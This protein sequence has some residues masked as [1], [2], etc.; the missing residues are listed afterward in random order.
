MSDSQKYYFVAASRKYLC[1]DEGKPLGE[2]LSERRRNFEARGKEINFWLIE[3]PAFLELPELAAV[4]RQIPQP[5]A[6][7]VTTDVNTMRW[8]KLRLE[9]VV[10]GEFQTSAALPD[11]LASLAIA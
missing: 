8:L 9:F 3:Q 6:A 10:T 1:E 2:T 7:I 4:K 5:A 11:P